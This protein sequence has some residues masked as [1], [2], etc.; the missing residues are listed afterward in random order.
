MRLLIV[1]DIHANSVSLQHLK[2]RADRVVFLGDAVDYGPRPAECVAWVRDRADF[3]V[4]G[5]HDHAVACDA[6]PQCSPAYR[7]MA[8]ATR[9]LHKHMLV[10]EDKAFLQDLPLELYFEFGGARFYAVH[11]S[12]GDPL[13]RYLPADIPDEQLALEVARIEAD[14]ILMGHTHL[15]SVRRIGTKLIVNPGSIGQPKD[16][17]PRAAYA[18][19]ED[20]RVLLQR[21]SYPV[22]KTVRQLQTQSLPAAVIGDLSRVLRTGRL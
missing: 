19:W 7:E 14:T 6:D 5:N 10:P 17:D 20:G 9:A 12:P 11:A 4:R 22:E 2:E 1:S 8:E 18:V 13:Y 3:A 15:P 16:G 21:Y